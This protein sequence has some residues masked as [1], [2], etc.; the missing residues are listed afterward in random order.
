[1][2]D[3]VN[4]PTSEDLLDGKGQFTTLEN[5]KEFWAPAMDTTEQS[6]DIAVENNGLV[7]KKKEDAKVNFDD[8]VVLALKG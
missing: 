3:A 7:L 8:G 1:M 4:S 5:F 6:Y 2:S